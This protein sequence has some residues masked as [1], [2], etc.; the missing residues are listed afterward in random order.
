MEMKKVKLHLDFYTVLITILTVVGF[1][2]RI[3]NLDHLTLWVDEYVHVDRAR[4]FPSQPLFTD[5][6]NGI[7]LTMF[8]IP[9]FKLFGATAFLARFPSV[10]FGTL[11]I[12]LLYMFGKKYF[13]K[14]VGLFAALFITFSEYFVF[15]SRI[16][17]NYAIFIF[18]FLLFVYFLGKCLNVKD[19][20]KRSG[21]KFFD[22]VSLRPKDGL[23]T[24]GCF[25]L[26]FL[27]HQLAFLVIYAI[28]FYHL[29]LFIRNSIIKKASYKS[30]NAVISYLF[31]IFCII[32]FVPSVQMMM[33]SVLMLFLPERIA[34]WVLPDLSRLSELFSIK[35][36]DSFNLY[37][38]ILKE[39]YNIIYITGFI[40]LAWALYKFKKS[41]IYLFS[42]FVIIFLL[43]SFIYREP[44]LPRYLIF[45][46]PFFFIAMAVICSEVVELCAHLTKSSYTKRI[47]LLGFTVLLVF[48]SPVSDSVAMVKNKEHGRI[49]PFTFSH[50]FF[51]DW[52]ST[53]TSAV[54]MIESNDVVMATI[55]TYPSFYLNRPTLQFRQMFYNT[56]T[57]KYEP[58]PI[59]TTKANAGSLEMLERLYQENKTGWLFADYYFNNILTDPQARNFI[60]R[61]TDMIYSL[62]NAYVRVFHWDN[63]Q[64][65]QYTNGLAEL[66]TPLANATQQYSIELRNVDAAG[67]Q[68][69]VE[70][71]GIDYDNELV[72]IV[73]GKQVGVQRKQ[74]DE[75]L[76]NKRQT[77]TVH[78]RKDFVKDGENT[79]QFVYN[80]N[81]PNP[82]NRKI[83]IYNMMFRLP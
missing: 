1:I 77:Y 52:K 35:P 59:D 65:H 37:F 61:N 83:A 53:L 5:D 75:R 23:I 66:I 11:S 76:G 72:I 34:V 2:M 74:G 49:V 9:F 47:I 39:D 71:E 33:K 12:P 20:F 22:Y 32:A 60:I 18:F 57:H 25:L 63:R 24:V 17:R 45:I 58:L 27:S 80:A 73:N 29:I 19:E 51:A 3:Y 68:M 16:S 79:I 56:T 21:S 46:Y 7:L 38:N 78:L 4:F 69:F 26:A 55:T 64:P 67:I 50:W 15:W 40:G 28:G 6:N 70:A 43:M 81:I 30:I 14:N 44:A 82:K 42:L 41:G 31:V 13:N 8:I 36:F 62:S 48:L 54:K 10:I